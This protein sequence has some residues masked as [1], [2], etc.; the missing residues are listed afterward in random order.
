MQNCALKE[1]H[2]CPPWGTSSLLD[3]D[4][5]PPDCF[6]KWGENLS[7]WG[8]GLQKGFLGSEELIHLQRKAV[9][10][11]GLFWLPASPSLPGGRVQVGEI[12]AF[13]V[14]RAGW[15]PP[16]PRQGVP[17]GCPALVPLV[18]SSDALIAAFFFLKDCCGRVGQSS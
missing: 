6:D 12:S 9:F 14:G 4:G 17:L 11:Q 2:P 1:G 18:V 15:A 16:A 8:T 5:L 3:A 7:F 10:S 13:G